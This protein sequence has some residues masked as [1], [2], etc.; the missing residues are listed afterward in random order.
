MRG[1][2]GV[3]FAALLLFGLSPV[4]QAQTDA[5]PKLVL[6]CQSRYTG[7]QIVT[8][9]LASKTGNFHQVGGEVAGGAVISEGDVGL[10]IT[11][12]NDDVIVWRVSTRDGNIFT[13][14]RYTGGMTVVWGEGAGSAAGQPGP[15]AQC[16]KQ[17]KQF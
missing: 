5:N 2:A 12:M 14:N 13:L 9:D 3:S 4:A 1:F 11:S 10:T 6:V 17:E 8:L 15:S 16:H 7:T